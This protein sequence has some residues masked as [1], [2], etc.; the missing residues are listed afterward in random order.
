M[1]WAISIVA[2]L[3]ILAAVVVTALVLVKKVQLE[4]AKD[5]M[6]KEAKAAKSAEAEAEWIMLRGQPRADKK[7]ASSDV[8]VINTRVQNLRDFVAIREIEFKYFKARFGKVALALWVIGLAGFLA[9]FL[10][11]YLQP[12][13]AA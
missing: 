1:T 10:V 11:M 9:Q 4:Q 3:S 6:Q 7:R 8:K 5:Q 2:V 12:G 13:S